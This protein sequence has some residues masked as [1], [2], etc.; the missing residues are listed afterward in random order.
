MNNPYST[1]RWGHQPATAVEGPIPPSCQKICTD[2]GPALLLIS[3]PNNTDTNTHMYFS[4]ITPKLR[5]DKD[6]DLT[7]N[8]PITVGSEWTAGGCGHHVEGA[9]IP[10]HN[11]RPHSIIGIISCAVWLG[12]ACSCIEIR[13]EEPLPDRWTHPLQRALASSPNNTGGIWDEDDG[14]YW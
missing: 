5:P 14:V 3:L 7:A 11:E 10:P 4:G 9:Y 8:E 6:W 1:T 2:L 12:P 13:A